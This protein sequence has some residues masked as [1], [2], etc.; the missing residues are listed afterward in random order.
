MTEAAYTYFRSMLDQYEHRLHEE[1]KAVAAE[2]T[3][4]PSGEVGT[5]MI[6]E[7]HRKTATA[8]VERRI[9]RARL[10]GFFEGIVV[11][12]SGSRP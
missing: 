6:A 12:L 10:E 5:R 7:A 1:G 2:P 9:V 4:V 8:V 11:T 3:A